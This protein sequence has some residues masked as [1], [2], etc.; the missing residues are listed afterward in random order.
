MYSFCLWLFRSP[1]CN[2]DSSANTSDGSCTYADTYDCNDVCLN[3][4]DND[5]V[6]DELE[7]AGCTDEN[8]FNYDS[9]A[10]DDNGSCIANSGLY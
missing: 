7:I 9:T 2:Y 10:T 8:A 6:C 4:A 3:D 1:A 5:D